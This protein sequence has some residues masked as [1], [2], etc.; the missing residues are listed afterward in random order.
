VTELARREEALR[1]NERLLDAI[2]EL[3]PVGVWI[4]DSTGRIV[5]NNPAGERIWGGARLVPAPEFDVYEGW[6]ADSGQRIAAEEWALSRALHRGETSIGEL[7]R[8]RAFDGTFKTIRNSALPLR[9]DRGAFAGAIV[10]NEDVTELRAQEEAARQALRERDR[11]L[12]VVSHDLRGPVAGVLM[13]AQLLSRRAEREGM[14]WAKAT[15]DQVARAARLMKRMISDL[16]DVASIESGRLS[17]LPEELAPEALVSDVVSLYAA[18]AS[19]LGVELVAEDRTGGARVS[20]DHDRILQVLSNLVGNALKFTPRG[21]RIVVRA[22]ER[23]KEVVFAVA[24][25][26]RGIPRERQRELF[27]RFWHA[28]PQD[29]RSRGIGLALARAIVEAHGGRIRVESEPDRGAT[30]EFSL[31]AR[32]AET[33]A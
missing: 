21:G 3:L 17:V 22:E 27:D 31:R 14:P 10:V 26:G 30:F 28:D 13:A 9:D 19:G 33:S 7:I 1:A 25:N 16:L 32:D 24:D 4:A 18:H 29:P 8:I 5:R 12:G 6:W 15:L 20:A 11:V 23:E 2:F